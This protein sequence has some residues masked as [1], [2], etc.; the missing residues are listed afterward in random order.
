MTKFYKV[1]GAKDLSGVAEQFKRSWCFDGKWHSYLR[2]DM[3]WK[4]RTTEDLTAE[5]INEIT[6]TRYY[7]NGTECDWCDEVIME[8][9]VSIDDDEVG[10]LPNVCRACLLRALSVLEG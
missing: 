6:G 8:D 4:L 3:Y 2:E 7:S 10:Y 1:H 9:M 5:K